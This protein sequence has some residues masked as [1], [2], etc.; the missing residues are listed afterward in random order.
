MCMNQTAKA[1]AFVENLTMRI[2]YLV[3]AVFPLLH[4]SAFAS[5][6]VIENPKE[7]TQAEILQA[8]GVNPD[9]PDELVTKLFTLLTAETIDVWLPNRRA[10]ELNAVHRELKGQ[11]KGESERI[12][13]ALDELRLNRP[14][15]PGRQVDAILR[16]LGA[17]G[18]VRHLE[19][20]A[21]SAKTARTSWGKWK[22]Y[23]SLQEIMARSNP[24]DVIAQFHVNAVPPHTAAI[25]L[26]DLDP[27]KAGAIAL[28]YDAIIAE[29]G[30]TG[31]MN[32]YISLMDRLWLA[33]S[34][35]HVN[36]N[37]AAE[38]FRR[39]LLS[40]DSALRLL[41]GLGLA[42]ITDQP[43][44]F[45]FTEDPGATE[46]EREDWLRLMQLRAPQEFTFPDPLAEP[47]RQSRYPG[48][49]DLIWLNEQAE[50]VRRLED[51]WPGVRRVLRDGTYYSEIHGE[52]LWGLTSPRG[53]IYTRVDLAGYPIVCEHGGVISRHGAESVAEFGPT[54]ELL[55][56]VPMPG[57]FSPT[58]RGQFLGRTDGGVKA[59]DRRGDVIWTMEIPE[60]DRVFLRKA[61]LV[62]PTTVMLEFATTI[63]LRERSGALLKRVEG[64]TS[65]QSVRFHPSK[66][67]LV[68]DNDGVVFDP[69]SGDLRRY[70]LFPESRRTTPSRWMRLYQVWP[71]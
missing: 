3:V 62:S 6:Y 21:V 19:H 4:V 44:P 2:T 23:A 12:A 35:R 31:Q 1:Y 10:L 28:T 65:V 67:W 25:L 17:V 64:F 43:I 50:V 22:A 48:G 68:Q 5:Q 59:I 14:R 40:H 20:I 70:R 49:V 41:A 66:P 60:K 13:Q 45:R 16:R 55:W 11:M 61:T 63:E 54:G 71:D 24:R 42:S 58:L 32:T 56:E 69:V 7:P 38:L 46:A 36:P 37:R 47:I 27:A 33:W 52:A 39:G 15:D 53:E 26:R 29:D 8:A 34:I 57:S 18:E 30:A 51:V 9:A